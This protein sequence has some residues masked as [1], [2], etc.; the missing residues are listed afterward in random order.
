MLGEMR[1]KVVHTVLKGLL[2]LPCQTSLG[3]SLDQHPLES[4]VMS[5]S[6]DGEVRKKYLEE[7]KL[8]FR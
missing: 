3:D 8:I 7:A 2:L 5:A 4:A 6:V 1:T